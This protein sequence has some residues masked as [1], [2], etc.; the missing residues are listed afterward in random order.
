MRGN[1]CVERALSFKLVLCCD[2]WIAGEFRDRLSDLRSKL[3]GS[4]QARS[5]GG[6]PC[7][8]LIEAFQRCLDPSERVVNLHCITGPF[9]TDG[10]RDRV[11]EV[12]P[13]DLDNLL[14][15]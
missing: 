14:P 2:K 9:L 4:V 13:A 11:F 5:N 8:E 12:G 7:C 1:D 15:C 3:F 10:E 6:S